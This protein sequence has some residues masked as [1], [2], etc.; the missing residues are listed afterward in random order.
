MCVY[1]V[2]ILVLLIR[3]SGW[4]SACIHAHAHTCLHVHAHERPLRGAGVGAHAVSSGG[5]LLLLGFDI[6]GGGGGGVSGVSSFV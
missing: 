6:V 5:A 3:L 4:R 1:S 2:G